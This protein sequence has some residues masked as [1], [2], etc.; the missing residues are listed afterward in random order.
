MRSE[1]VKGHRP[2]SDPP[3]SRPQR[4]GRVCLSTDCDTRLSIYNKSGFCW[5]HQ[6]LIFPNYRGK[7]L[8]NS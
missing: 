1:N 3:P 7:R 2:G 4:V 6:P 5:L 8:V